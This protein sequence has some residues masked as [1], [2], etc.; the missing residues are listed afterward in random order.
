MLTVIAS[1]RPGLFSRV[2]G[3]LA[4]NG[5]DVLGGRG[6]LERRGHGVAECSGSRAPGHRHRLGSEVIGRPAPALDGRL[7]LE[8]RLA[9][10][11]E[12]T[13]AGRAAGARRAERHVRQRRCPA[14]A[15]VVEVRCPDRLGVLYRITRALAELDLDIRSAK[16]QTLGH[17]VVDSFYV[18][19]VSGQKVTDPELPGRDRAGDLLAHVG[20]ALA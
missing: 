15:T 17:D 10:R 12:T 13:R 2:G 1:D 18:R 3:V 7:A 6:L 16:V 19:D 20:S 9:D 8:A 4:L 14:T 11:A 5:L